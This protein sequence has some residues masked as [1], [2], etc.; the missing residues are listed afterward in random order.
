[1][2]YPIDELNAGLAKVRE[3]L[4]AMRKNPRADKLREQLSATIL[5]VDYC[6]SR[7][8]RWAN[9]LAA[10]RTK[11]KRLERELAKAIATS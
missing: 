4:L 1:M 9:K 6:E 3:Q 8:I 7:L 10:V 11:R 5:D 2:R